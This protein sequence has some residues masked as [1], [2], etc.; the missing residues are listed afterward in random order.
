MLA[1]KTEKLQNANDKLFQASQNTQWLIHQT[2]S[3][4]AVPLLLRNLQCVR[5]YNQS[6]NFQTHHFLSVSTTNYL[7]L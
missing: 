3:Y 1:N 7:N 6:I 4:Q 2:L 5:S